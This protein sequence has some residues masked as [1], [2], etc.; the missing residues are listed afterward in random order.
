MNILKHIVGFIAVGFSVFVFVQKKRSG[1]LK[2][3]LL[4]DFLWIM[5]FLFIGAYTGMATTAISVF[6]ELLFLKRDEYS[7]LKKPFLIPLFSI[8]YL[9]SAMFTWKN[10][11]CILPPMASTLAT[12]G[13]WQTNVT[14]IRILGLCVSLLMLAYGALNGSIFTVI[15]EVFTISSLIYCFSRKEI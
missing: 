15:N 5:H 13:F 3:K 10:I 12:V 1:I 4:T 11:A 8:C 9:I 6:R 2:F 7:F 14:T